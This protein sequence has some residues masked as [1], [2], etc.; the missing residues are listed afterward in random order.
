MS[1]TE[2]VL[3]KVY[4]GVISAA[5]AL[6]AQKVLEAGW[7]SFTGED[8]T[9]DPT[10]PDTPLREAIVWALASGIGMGA[11]QLFTA[12]FAERRMRVL[13]DS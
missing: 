12:R 8:A 11:A 6:V 13:A 2:K 5:V 1:L 10:D 3:V 7:K 9:P 4:T